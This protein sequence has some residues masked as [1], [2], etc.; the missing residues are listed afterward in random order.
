MRLILLIV[1]ATII[2]SNTLSAQV[3][4]DMYFIHF[5]D[6]NNNPYTLQQ[7]EQYLSPRAIQRRADNQIA[8]DEYDIPVTP[9]YVDSMI[10]MGFDVISKTKY[11]NG[12][13]VYT[14]N[15]LLLSQLSGISFVD[16]YRSCGEVKPSAKLETDLNNVTR[17]TDVTDYGYGYTQ[18]NQVK[19]DY[20]HNLDFKG[21]GMLISVIDAGFSGADTIVAFDNLFAAGRVVYTWDVVNR[22]QNVYNYHSHGTMVL[23]VMASDVP[24]ELVG[25]APEATYAL[26]RTEEGSTE[27][28]VEE[29]FLASGFELADSLG[30]DVVNVSLGYS[31]FDDINQNHTWAD[32]DGVTAPASN[33][34]RIAGSRGMIILASAG[35][36]GDDPW[37]KITFPADA[38]SILT[39]GSVNYQGLYSTFSSIGPTEDGRVKPDVVAM[40]QNTSVYSPSGYVF[41]GSGTSFSSPLLC[42]LTACLWQATPQLLPYEVMNYIR[43]SA[44]QFA[45]PDEFRGYGLPDFELAYT[46]VNNSDEHFANKDFFFSAFPNPF[47]DELNLRIFSSENKTLEIKLSDMLGRTIKTVKAQVSIGE[48]NS[49]KIDTE[50]NILPGLYIIEINSE[51]KKFNR[52]VSKQ[53]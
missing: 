23:S 1:F 52:I 19:G 9:I 38:D 3:A 41:Q 7:P 16:G 26:I 29:Y 30:S 21:Q 33:A 13:V 15:T 24:G 34:A 40:G 50:K 46:M 35:N 18:I 49:I 20:L 43:M 8:I 5:T 22:Q 25:T 32:L 17:N 44:D 51:G 37:A 4:P 27:N 47:N 45:N 31:E 10:A 36:S 53:Q 39:I 42:G 6:K 11:L 2:L 28:I 12:V 48:Y 14:T